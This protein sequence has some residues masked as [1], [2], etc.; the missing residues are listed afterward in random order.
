MDAERW[1][2]IERVFHAALHTEPSRRAKILEDSCAGDE[3]LRRE[4]ESLLAH[5]ANADTF[6]ETPA[7]ATVKPRSD[8]L[9]DLDR[10]SS[11]SGRTPRFAAGAIFGHYRLLEEIGG[12]GMGV[13]YCAEDVKLERQVA[14]KFLPEESADDSVALERFRR[15]AR[16]ASALNH[17][18]ICTIYEIDEADGRA[19]IA[20]EL[21]EGQT[22]RDLINL[23]PL[24][25]ETVLDLTIQI[26]DALD[27]A[28][29]K[30]IV[31]RDIKPANIFVTSRRQT[32]ILDFG[33]A[34]FV[35][36]TATTTAS[37]QR[38]ADSDQLTSPGSTLG[39][40]AYMS[41]EQV[42]GEELDA[43]TDLFSLG[44]V[45]Y[46]MCTG[47]LPFRGDTSALVFRAILDRQPTPVVRINPEVPLELERIINKA[48][49]KDRE[50]RY[51]SAA[52]LRS[53]L[54]RLRRDS[55][56]GISKAAAPNERPARVRRTAFVLL[57]IALVAALGVTLYRFARPSGP[58]GSGW[59]QLTFFTDSAVFPALSPDGRMLAFIRGEELVVVDRGDL[60]LKLL[61]DGKPVQLTHDK[62]L[63]LSPAFSPDGSRIAYGAFD[64]WETWE[65][66]V[67]GGEPRLL[68]PNSSSLTWIQDGK[69]LLFSE[70][71]Q[72][73]HMAVVTSDEARGQ[74]RD[75]Y[76]PPGE[77]S[78]AH[79][80]YLSPDG[81]WVLVVEMNNQGGIGPCRAVPFDGRGNVRV[82]GPPDAACTS[83]AW[84]PDGKWLY[85]SSNQGGKF[86]IWRQQFPGGTPEQVT[87]GPT[88]EEGIA[89]AQD[90]RSLITSVGIQDSTVWIHDAQ[91]ERQIS[92]EGSARAPQFSADSRQ[93]YY[94]L[95]YG[96]TAGS[97]LWVS[98]LATGTSKP[99]LSGYSLRGCGVVSQHY[100]L[101]KDGTQIAFS[102]LDKTGHFRVWTAPTDRRSS[103]KAI[104]SS[105]SE[106]CPDFLPNGDLV[107]RAVEGDSHF[108][109]RMKPNGTERRKISDREIFDPGKVSH[110]GRWILAQA[111]GPDREHP[112]SVAAF[113]IDGGPTVPVCLSLCSATWDRTGKSLYIS[114][115][116][117]G[118]KNTYALPL[119]RSGLPRLPSAGISSIEELNEWKVPV[120]AP[121]IVESGGMLL[122]SAHT[123]SVVRRNLYRIPLP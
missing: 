23:K 123:R 11:T 31:H 36:R 17:S 51:Q 47:T 58:V 32:K 30:G 82:V 102:M 72:G 88:E 66:P 86:H 74:S 120:V 91:G 101:S 89:M 115:I 75:V 46:Q 63:K 37:A 92:A 105:T 77:R 52:E 33:L 25:V 96:Q 68:L 79:H 103:P 99:V 38:T 21:L 114:L 19:F 5:H 108:L 24:N 56:T 61:P 97:E 59:Q 7:F 26:A 42:R 118:N 122:P 15:E 57:M 84:S 94:L 18:N 107:F 16:A 110:D 112:Y 76:I 6:M 48:L 117:S 39:T 119:E 98:D 113:P 111:Q 3:S 64:P 65:V 20:M 22:L 106:D 62:R 116:S 34:K 13:V 14:L 69:R 100:S 35:P 71:K 4:V 83:G 109:Y 44:A 70:I 53:D 10:P 41:P 121:E 87:S 2:K 8:P 28:H 78:M 67:F 73:L 60:Y 43:R 81:G 90:G 80:S 12:G 54:K 45:L 40:V 29:T 27:A 95:S 49:E 1:R 104:E 93:L 55:E 50:L 85:I 9:S